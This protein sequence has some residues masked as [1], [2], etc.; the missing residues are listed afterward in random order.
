MAITAKSTLKK[1]LAQTDA[2]DDYG[3]SPY[4]ALHL[5]MDHI[6]V[7]RTGSISFAHTDGAPPL[8]DPKW[9]YVSHAHLSEC[10]K[11]LDS[12]DV[13]VD[14][15]VNGAVILKTANTTYMT[16]LRVHTTRRENSGFKTHTPGDTYLSLDPKWLGG[17]DSRFIPTGSVPVVVK[18]HLLVSTSSGSLRWGLLSDPGV[19]SHP[20]LSFLRAVSNTDD[21]MMELTR[22]GFYHT[23]VDGMHLYTASHQTTA[24]VDALG[25]GPAAPDVSVVLPAQRLVAAIRQAMAVAAEGVP[26]TFSAKAGILV[27]D[28]YGNSDRFSLGDTGAFR[29]FSV[30]QGPAKFM[31]E[32]LSQTPE[33]EAIYTHV[34]GHPEHI[35]ITRGRCEVNIHIQPQ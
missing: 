15:L 21:A 12:D 4:V 27:R 26:L 6:H 19:P 35:R 31:V 29:T 14:T 23:L 1:A 25:L 17:L 5:G 16:E 7:Y 18:D 30:H 3:R 20:R 11:C 13:E 2:A 33:A 34:Q 24:M 22:A 28:S 10:L 8:S 32:A 9:V